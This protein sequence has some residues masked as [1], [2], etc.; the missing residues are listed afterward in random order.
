MF[1]QGN[2]KKCHDVF[3]LMGDCTPV[4]VVDHSTARIKLKG[5]VTCL[6]NCLHVP[7]LIMSLFFTTKHGRNAT[8]CSFLL[9]DSKMHLT[10]PTFSVTCPIPANGDLQLDLEDLTEDDWGIPTHIYNG[11]E[12]DASHLDDFGNVLYF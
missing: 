10:F 7:S 6:E 5:H 4:P 3:I 2:Y 9:V 11:K 1:K 8:G 12:D